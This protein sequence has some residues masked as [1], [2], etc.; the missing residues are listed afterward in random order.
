VEKPVPTTGRVAPLPTTMEVGKEEEGEV[1][2]IP[3]LEVM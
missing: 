1:V 2:T 3:G